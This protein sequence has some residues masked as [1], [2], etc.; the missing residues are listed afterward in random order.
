MANNAKLTTT[1]AEFAAAIKLLQADLKILRQDVGG[2]KN[3]AG[4]GRGRKGGHGNGQRAGT[5]TA[6]GKS[7][8]PNCKREVFH[9]P[10]DCF[11]LEKNASKRPAIWRSCL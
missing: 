2:L 3:A 1:N 8:C 9:L 10:D 5:G 4:S 6:R 7:L 11:E